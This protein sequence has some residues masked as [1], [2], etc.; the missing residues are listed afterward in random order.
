MKLLP[1]GMMMV[2]CA[3]SCGFAAARAAE[4]ACA[5]SGRVLDGTKAVAGAKVILYEYLQDRLCIGPLKTVTSSADGTYRFDGLHG[6]GYLVK[7]TAPH[8]VPGAVPS[9]AP[10]LRLQNLEAGQ[11]ATIDIGL[12]TVARLTLRLRS[13]DGKPLAGATLQECSLYSPDVSNSCVD[14]LDHHVVVFRVEKRIRL[15]R[16]QQSQD[17]PPEEWERIQYRLGQAE[18]SGDYLPVTQRCLTR[19]IIPGCSER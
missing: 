14:D 13:R 1:L 5:I 15:R 19:V 16:S 3:G 12:Q 11:R 18:I 8:F 7:A 9:F 2:V 6:S 17:G 10:A 4:T